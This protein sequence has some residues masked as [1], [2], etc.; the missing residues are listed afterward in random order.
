VQA[1]TIVVRL[2]AFGANGFGCGERQRAE[3]RV[4]NVATHVA[5]GAGAEVEPLAPVARMII[6]VADEGPLGRDA[7]PDVP[8]QSGRDRIFAFWSRIPVA[9][10]LAA[11]AVD[12]GNLADRSGLD[13]RDDRSVLRGRV[14]LDAH[15][16]DDLPVRGHPGELPGLVNRLRERFLCVDMQSAL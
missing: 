15:L 8:I 16:A 14:D 13:D 4:K 1:P 5:E 11:P 6:T 10:L 3:H 2:V 12:F 7:E 9:P